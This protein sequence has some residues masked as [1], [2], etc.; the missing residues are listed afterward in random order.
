M[1]ILALFRWSAMPL[2]ERREDVSLPDDLPQGDADVAP[3][4]DPEWDELLTWAGVRPGQPLALDEEAEWATLIARVRSS[5]ASVSPPRRP[6]DEEAEWATLIA[7]ARSAPASVPPPG[8]PP[9]P[10]P[11]VRSPVENLWDVAIRRAK[12]RSEG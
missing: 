12:A 11:T 2:G 7:R 10:A 3:E 9:Q 5:P 4:P 6:L 8:R 1:G